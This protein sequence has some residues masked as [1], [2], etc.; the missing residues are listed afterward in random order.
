[1]A[2]NC[3]YTMRFYVDYEKNDLVRVTTAHWKDKSLDVYREF[4]NSGKIESRN[5]YFSQMGGWLVSFPGEVNKRGYYNYF[6]YKQDLEEWSHEA[7]TDALMGE[8]EQNIKDVKVMLFEVDSK[9]FY[10]CKKLDSNFIYPKLFE[11]VRIYREHPECETLIQYGFYELALNKSLY[12]L[13]KPKLKQVLQ[14]VNELKNV[15]IYGGITLRQIQEYNLHWKDKI[16]TIKEWFD[17]Y[18]ITNNFGKYGQQL[19]YDCWK[20][21]QRKINNS[22]GAIQI[23]K[24]EYLDYLEMAKKVGHNIEDP[25]WRYPND[26]RKMHDKVMEQ[27]NAVSL[28]KLALQQDFLRIVC[29]PMLKYNKEINGYNIF[30]ST[31]AKEWKQ[32]CDDLYQC[33][34]RNGYMKKVIDQEAIIVFIWKD[35]KPIA[36]AE[37]DYKKNIQQFYGDERGHSRGESCKP[38]EEVEEAFN[39]WLESF[40]P[41]KAKFDYD[42]SIHYYKGFND[43][44][45]KETFHTNCGQMDG[46][47][48]GSSFVLGNVYETPFD[49]DEILAAGG[50]GC[51][52][53]P[54]VFHFCSSISEI[55]RHYSPN[56]YCEIKPLG[57]VVEN[58]GALL[59]NKIKIVRYLQPEEVEAIKILEMQKGS[60]A[61]EQI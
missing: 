50:I 41:K 53:T 22:K 13:S 5:L 29:K 38:N 44:D 33:L 18:G 31:E 20:Y 3:N 61:Y 9:L 4:L 47:G 43:F 42:A 2:H 30:I 1:M 26:F 17:W 24:Y 35:G 25:Y 27:L 15:S 32:T 52:S 60:Y 12:R 56:Y 45:G 57:A 55:A 59:S 7:K 10:F 48:K 49:D 16:S 21:I 37:L 8:C 11:L 23:T 40:K 36:T 14:A 54:K 6:G 19:D 51:V 28:A 58:D 46:S 34:I 39:I